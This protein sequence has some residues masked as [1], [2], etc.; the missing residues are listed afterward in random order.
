MRPVV[1]VGGGI[2]GLSTAYFLS[3]AGIPVT[4]IEREPKLG[5]L[6]QTEHIDGC[7]VEAGPDSFITNKPGARELI[8]EL[9]M[10]DDVIGSNDD[11]RATYIWKRGQL[12]KMPDGLTM[13]VPG[14]IGPMLTTPLLGLGAKL[15]AARELF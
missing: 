5:G 10:S 4:I 8:D 13:M 12:I 15:H 14:K 7:V 3:R 11:R 2:S 9:G 6:I 1:I